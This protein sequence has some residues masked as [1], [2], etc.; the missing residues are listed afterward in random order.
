MKIIEI[1]KRDCENCIGDGRVESGYYAENDEFI[2]TSTVECEECSGTGEEVV[3][4]EPFR[5]WLMENLIN[6]QT[7]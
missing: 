5:E 3:M 1:E 2:P 6:S 4:I 7:H